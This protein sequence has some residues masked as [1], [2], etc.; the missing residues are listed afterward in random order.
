MPITI[1]AMV[2]TGVPPSF[3]GATVT[4]AG[5]VDCGVIN[6][7]DA[8][9]VENAVD[10]LALLAVIRAAVVEDVVVVVVEASLIL[11]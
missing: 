8:G 3:E 4:V 6:P 1:P 5:D 9:V 7:D 2:L 10:K 11:K